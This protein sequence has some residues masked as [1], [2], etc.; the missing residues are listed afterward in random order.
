MI[1]NRTNILGRVL[2]LF[3]V[4]MGVA[5]CYAQ[6]QTGDTVECRNTLRRSSDVETCRTRCGEEACRT[7]CAEQERYSR[8]HHCWVE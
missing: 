2:A 1:M 3:I 6:V 5:A 4:G 8:E 7:H